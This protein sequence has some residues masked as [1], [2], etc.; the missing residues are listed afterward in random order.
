MSTPND[1]NLERA[2][3]MMENMNVDDLVKYWMA[4]GPCHLGPKIERVYPWWN[5]LLDS[6][7]NV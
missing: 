1:I 4:F 3:F 6:N 7:G 5:G 2:M